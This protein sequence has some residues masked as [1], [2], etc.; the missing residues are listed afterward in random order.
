MKWIK[1]RESIL[2]NISQ[3]KAILRKSGESTDNQDYLKIIEKTNKDGYT[4]ILTKLVFKEGVDID[5][6][7][8][9]YD[10]LKDKKINVGD[11]SKKSYDDILDF[12]Y[13]EESDS[14]INF[15][16]EYGNYYVF[17]VKDYE[18]GLN[19]FSPSW[20]LKT[21]KYWE[22]YCRKGINI[23][24][25]DKKY[26]NKRGKTKLPTPNTFF[27]EHYTNTK[28]PEIRFGITV[29]S[30]GTGFEYYD[31]D[32]R[33]EKKHKKL[34]SEISN[35]SREYLDF[36]SSE[37]RHSGEIL[38]DLI[39]IIDHFI[40]TES[41]ISAMSFDLGG[42]ALSSEATG[43]LEH[44][45]NNTEYPA[46]KTI[47]ETIKDNKEE[48]LSS[49]EFTQNNGIYDMILYIAFKGM[50]HY[51]SG[52]SLSERSQYDICF[53]YSYGVHKTLWGREMISQSYSKPLDFYEEVA[54][55]I[56]KLFI[57]DDSYGAITGDIFDNKVTD[58]DFENN[59]VI[60]EATK[61]IDLT[62]YDLSVIEED[63]YEVIIDFDAIMDKSGKF[64]HLKILKIHQGKGLFEQYI[65]EIYNDRI[66]Q[67]YKEIINIF[68]SYKLDSEKG[69]AY[70]I[71]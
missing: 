27:G 18:A 56:N 13:S 7:L 15:I 34:I 26:A 23:V 40:E 12:V 6:V 46:G 66:F 60:N 43:K 30:S 64:E 65:E 50:E 29:Y 45:L 69:K 4:G 32:N 11:I 1:R 37:F 51:L 44:F 42:F 63:T 70:I 68:H 35:K 58:K 2:E 52:I 20:C 49:S 22:T 39:D 48:I 28:K 59:V 61:K 10:T 33:M 57:E 62:K 16:F 41:T 14:D 55:N 47:L 25:I 9:L 3:A 38:D 31:D 67:E 54:E 71:I 19:M 36:G 24:A 5:E 53:R 17:E 8:S 21:K